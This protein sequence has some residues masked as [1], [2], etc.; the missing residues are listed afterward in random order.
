MYQYDDYRC[1]NNANEM[2]GMMYQPNMPGMM[3]V[4]NMPDMGN[5]QNMYMT[6]MPEYYYPMLCMPCQKMEAMYPKV[7]HMINDRVNHYCNMMDMK[8]GPMYMPSKDEMDSMA[9]DIYKDMAPQVEQMEEYQEAEENTQRQFGFGG[10]RL[11]RDLILIQLIRELIRRR[12]RRPG[13]VYGWG[14]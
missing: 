9:E 11:L 2:Q 5:P 10:R 6:G 8:Y 7:Y 12:R 13:N 14:M 1:N 3:S 4:Q